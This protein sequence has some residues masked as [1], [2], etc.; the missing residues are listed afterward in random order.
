ME[1]E[2]PQTGAYGHAKHDESR[3]RMIS[4]PRLWLVTLGGARND[5]WV[6]GDLAVPAPLVTAPN[7]SLAGEQTAL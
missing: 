3:G 5:R 4:S 6:V 7:R 2:V 1:T